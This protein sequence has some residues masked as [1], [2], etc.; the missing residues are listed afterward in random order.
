MEFYGAFD[1]ERASNELFW[2]D[3]QHF[4]SKDIE[5]VAINNNDN[6][7]VNKVDFYYNQ[8][9]LM[10]MPSDIDEM[11]LFVLY[12]KKNR[13]LY[14]MA[15]ITTSYLNM[16]YVVNNGVLY[17]STSLKKLLLNSKIERKI[18]LKSASA[19]IQNGYVFGDKTLIEGVHKID[20][21]KFL[22]ATID[23]YEQLPYEFRFEDF[24]EWDG[25]CLYKNVIIDSIENCIKNEEVL[26]MPL[27]GGYDSNCIL[28]TIKKYSDCIVN[29]FTIGGMN[30]NNEIP[31]AKHIATVVPGVKH[32][33][34]V[35]EPFCLEKFADIIWRL[36]GS[37]YESGIFLQYELSKLAKEHGCKKLIC[38]ESNN[39]IQS[40]LYIC[41]MKQ[42]IEGSIDLK[43]ELLYEHNPFIATNLMVL[44]KSSIMLN[45]FGIKGVYP[46]KN[47]KVVECSHA[48]RKKNLNRELFKNICK[49]FISNDVLDVIKS[50]GG[51]TGIGSIFKKD[52]MKD[53]R[54]NNSKSGIVREINKN[55]EVIYD[56]GA[57]KYITRKYWHK[58][59]YLKTGDS[60]YMD[61]TPIKYLY[62]R[63]FYELFITGKYDAYFDDESISI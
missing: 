12:D 14:L 54:Y 58:Y 10:D 38:G 25:V 19:F 57:F 3:V 59:K 47:K 33:S 34:K 8:G 23:G 48:V 41:N 62:I 61:E 4:E 2:N 28:A 17:Y 13:K 5:I 7:F 31:V 30:G 40:E 36:E 55:K 24:S 18:D 6:D 29:A 11:F 42:V 53:I 35:A 52:I 45:S 44:K 22:Y 15:D 51:T 39:E 9:R 37:V 49:E 60:G 43:S 63:A 56:G 27:S 16:Y 46:F 26:Y 32:Y 1:L 50:V 21:G 20:F